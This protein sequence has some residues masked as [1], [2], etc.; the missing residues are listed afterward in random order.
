MFL[1][2]TNVISELRRPKPHGAVLSWI[3]SVDASDLCLSAVS[4]GE[5]QTGIERTR[6]RDAAKAAEIEIWADIALQSFKILPMDERAFRLW[7]QLMQG[8]SD[9]V[10][11]DAMIASTAR[12]NDLV[13]VTRNVKDFEGLGV[14]VVNPFRDLHTNR[15]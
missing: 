14:E 12:V 15:V 6:K 9:T 7:A 5:I 8:R 11:F 13:V 1:L 2:D 4:F 3:G 10:S